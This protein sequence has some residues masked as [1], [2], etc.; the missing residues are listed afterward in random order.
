MLVDD[1]SPAIDDK[2]LGHAV[3]APFDCRPAVAVH[4]DREIWVAVAAK[5]AP[6]GRRLVLVVDA[7]DAHAGPLFQGHQNGVLLHARHAPRGPEVH[8][9]DLA[10]GQI[11]AG[12]AADRAPRVGETLQ[13]LELDG[14]N[15]LADQR[16]GEL[17]RVA[18]AQRKGEYYG[19]DAEDPERQ[20]QRPRSRAT[21]FP[22]P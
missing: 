17:G 22:S 14:R 1:L 16:G 3:D 21:R 5:E 18:G 12:K 19:Q 11:R 20:D 8:D 6:R 15:G 13:A 2:R 9:R 4:A 7:E 10:P